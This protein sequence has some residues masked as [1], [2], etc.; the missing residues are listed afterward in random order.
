MAVF[1]HKRVVFRWMKESDVFMLKAVAANQPRNSQE[2]KAI[3]DSCS[4]AYG[5]GKEITPRAVKDRLKHLM[6]Q[7]KKRMCENIAK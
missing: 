3:A 6:A 4:V 7:H 1:L 5:K 2:W